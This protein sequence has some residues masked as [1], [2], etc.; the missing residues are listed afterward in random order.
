MKDSFEN[1]LVSVILPI[2][3]VESY[4]RRC[5]ET[6]ISQTYNNLEIILIDDG[7]T[8]KSGDICDY[9]SHKDSRIKVYHTVNNGLSEA[10]NY[11][12][13]VSQGD[14]ILYVD[15]DD[16][17]NDVYI[18]MMYNSLISSNADFVQ[19]GMKYVTHYNIKDVNR[20]TDKECLLSNEEYMKK[21]LIGESSVSVAGKL[22]KR[23]LIN[24]I[25]NP[26][27]RI[28]EDNA[29]ICKY[30]YLSKYVYI[31]N[32]AIYYYTA[33]RSDSITSSVSR[34]GLTDYIWSYNMLIK[35]CSKYFPSLRYEAIDKYRLSIFYLWSMPVKKTGLI[36]LVFPIFKKKDKNYSFVYMKV[37]KNYISKHIKDYLKMPFKR[38]MQALSICY[39]PFPYIVY[40]KIREL[41]IWLFRQKRIQ[42]EMLQ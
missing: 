9:Y 6:V 26:V 35:D 4:L 25:K 8:D 1:G 30:V 19:S 33:I 22:F 32:R 29:I 14:Y 3:N 15:P 11:G 41:P 21:V 31:E 18:E 23:F 24:S 5:I 42:K 39:F 38:R 28:F 7:S 34:R 37:A 17:I 12:F 16:W 40:L 36:Y 27:G 10:R 13:D 2:Y 20:F